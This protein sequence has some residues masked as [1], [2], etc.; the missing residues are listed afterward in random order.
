MKLRLCA[1][2]ASS[3]WLAASAHAQDLGPNVY[4]IKDGIYVQHGRDAN[5]SV[6][7]ILTTEGVVVIDS[8]QSLIDTREAEAAVKKLTPL[9]IKYLIDTE[10]HPD[11]TTGNFVFSPP[12]IVINHLGAG[13]AMRKADNPN[14][15]Q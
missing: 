5:S 3:M 8:G 4:K 15:A 12:A 9:P 13:D 2:V 7:I 6:G 14:R 1:V 10:V 11:H